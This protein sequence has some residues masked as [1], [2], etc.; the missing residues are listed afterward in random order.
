MKCLPMGKGTSSAMPYY[1]TL[2]T[3]RHTCRPKRCEDMNIKTDI[4]LPSCRCV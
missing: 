4:A 2:P 1:Y 3:V